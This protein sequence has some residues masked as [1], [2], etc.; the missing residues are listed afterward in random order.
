M[1]ENFVSVVVGCSLGQDF[2][3]ILKCV[4]R[5]SRQYDGWKIFKPCQATI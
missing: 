3:D 2:N 5:L 1:Y 4:Y